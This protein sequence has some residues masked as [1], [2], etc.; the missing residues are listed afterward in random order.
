MTDINAFSHS[1]TTVTQGF[2]PRFSYTVGA[3][4]HLGYEIVFAGGCLLLSDEIPAVFSSVMEDN[5]D[6]RLSLW[7]RFGKI[8]LRDAH[9]SWAPVMAL[10]AIR[11]YPGRTIK[12]KQAY[13]SDIR[14]ID[15]PDMTKP[16]N[17][18]INGSW[19]Y[20]KEAW[21]YCLAESASALLD[22]D[23]LKGK[24]L[25]VA[26]RYED[27]Y[28]EILSNN[29]FDENSRIIPISV[30][31]EYW[32]SFHFIINMDNETQICL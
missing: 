23:A 32:P 24:D 25:K 5:E 20:L 27:D 12:L 9:P 13:F 10:N 31:L 11:Q 4:E 30:I 21:P 1:I 3:F 16:Y 7:A 26:S 6:K 22:L 19:K 14:T 2:C 28:W 15:D 18:P 8:K 29:S 17:D